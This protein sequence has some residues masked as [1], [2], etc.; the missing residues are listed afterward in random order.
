MKALSALLPV[1]YPAHFLT[2]YRAQNPVSIYQR[3]RAM[4]GVREGAIEKFRRVGAWI[5]NL[6]SGWLEEKMD[7]II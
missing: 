5:L 3:I 6:C 7:R 2:Q 4:R 1:F